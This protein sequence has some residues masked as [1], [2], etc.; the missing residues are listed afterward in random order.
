MIS[1]HWCQWANANNPV[2]LLAV[3]G[4]PH[5]VPRQ[6]NQ[7]EFCLFNYCWFSET[8]QWEIEA[9]K[10]RFLLAPHSS[11]WLF[12]VSD[13]ARCYHDSS[14]QESFEKS[15]IC[16]W[17]AKSLHFALLFGIGMSYVY[18]NL[19]HL[20]KSLASLSTR[21]CCVQIVMSFLFKKCILA[22]EFHSLLPKAKDYCNHGLCF[23]AESYMHWWEIGL[24]NVITEILK[25][26]KRFQ[27]I[28]WCVCAQ[29][30]K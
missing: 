3:C 13:W 24:I 9:A 26:S 22:S 28:F 10:L 15:S 30:F 6:V 19:G 27:K 25:F 4:C 20:N 21:L 29:V 16:S 18:D 14:R 5:S 1:L 8:P 7:G 12:R 23:T 11:I 2:K 17:I